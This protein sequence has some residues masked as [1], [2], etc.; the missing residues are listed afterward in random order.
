MNDQSVSRRCF[1]R[2]SVAT[3]IGVTGIGTLPLSAAS[4]GYPS[5]RIG[6]CADLHQ[7]IMHDGPERL[8]TFLEAMT[9][10][11]PDFIIQLGD[12]RTANPDP[13]RQ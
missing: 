2:N 9:V 6:I 13:A 5:I 1:L 12:S 3:A 10:Q 8:T 11:R 4:E 7:D